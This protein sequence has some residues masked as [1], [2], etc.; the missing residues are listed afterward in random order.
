MIIFKPSNDVS[1]CI[2]EYFTLYGNDKESLHKMDKLLQMTDS[3][4]LKELFGETWGNISSDGYVTVLE[5]N[6]ESLNISNFVQKDGE[7]TRRNN[8]KILDFKNVK[9]WEMDISNLNK[10]QRDEN[11]V[12]NKWYQI[13]QEFW[14]TYRTR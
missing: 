11:N 1:M 14:N 4:V 3:Q 12:I 2:K 13:W 10:G 7:S 5:L 6:D 9:P 8:A